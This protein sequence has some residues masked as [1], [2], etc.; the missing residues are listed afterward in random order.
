MGRE[1]DA[2]HGP[3]A[4]ED[5]LGHAA[6]H[7]DDERRDS[8]RSC[9]SVRVTGGPH[10]TFG[11]STV[12]VRYSGAK[13]WDRLVAVLAVAGSSTPI[14]AG[15][16]KLTAASGKVTIKLMNEAVRF[17]AGKKLVLYLSSTSLA[18]S[19]ARRALS[20]GGAAGRA[21]HD[22]PRHA[23]P[24][25][26]EEGRLPVR[27]ALVAL[28]ALLA[29]P[30]A[31][32]A[33]PGVTPTQI[34]LGATGPLSGSESAYAPTL[35]G[36]QA[37]FDYVNAHGGVNGRKIVYKVEDDQYNPVETVHAHAEARR[38]GRRVRDLQLDRHRAR[39]RRAR[40]PEHAQGAAALRRQRRRR[41]RHAA[42]EVPVDDRA[43][44]RASPAKGLIYGRLIAKD[45]PKAKIGVLYENDEYGHELLA[46]L[47]RGLGSHAARSSGR[48]R[49][50]C[51]T[52][53]SCRRCSR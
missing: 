18:Q 23:E 15:G 17:A 32:A 16:V 21:D 42:C 7:V 5:D 34:V 38:A 45:H 36:A 46:G 22:R 31:G 50:R 1:D 4:D 19:S 35:T 25:G 26:A 11:D 9:A 53:A 43:R 27:L 51:S 28:V 37:Y 47:K 44:C 3:A 20:R 49:T 52:R 41:D 2:L 30:A 10:E 48:S 12:V 39:A 6:G 40:L 33:T 8:A 24:L 13:N 14:T 29:V